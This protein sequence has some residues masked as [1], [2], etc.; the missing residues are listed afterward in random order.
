MLI[1]CLSALAPIPFL[2]W[3]LL[4]GARSRG[5][6]RVLGMVFTACGVLA[7]ILAFLVLLMNGSEV[8]RGRL[9]TE[10]LPAVL[11]W[12]LQ[13]VTAVIVLFGN[14][15]VA[16]RAAGQSSPPWFSKVRPT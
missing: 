15:R 2:A 16:F 5:S 4:I 13:A 8:A 3:W 9:D 14:A 6:A 10:D 12:T 11:V 1:I 7:W